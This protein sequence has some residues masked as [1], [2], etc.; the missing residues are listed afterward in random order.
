MNI[1]T[2][3]EYDCQNFINIDELKVVVFHQSLTSVDRTFSH[4][5]MSAVVMS[6]V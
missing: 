5:L 2:S 4:S 6:T 3:S 1:T